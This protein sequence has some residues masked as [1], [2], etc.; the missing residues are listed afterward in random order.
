MSL[1]KPKS[2]GDIAEGLDLGDVDFD[3][4]FGTS[5]EP[6]RPE[7]KPRAPRLPPPLT[8]PPERPGT[9][10]G[11]TSKPDPP[12]TPRSGRQTLMGI[13]VGSVFD[14]EPDDTP[15]TIELDDDDFES[16]KTQIAMGGAKPPLPNLSADK[17]PEPSQGLGDLAADLD[18]IEG[19]DDFDVEK[20]NIAE[21]PLI[22]PE[23]EKGLDADSVP[24]DD[25]VDD[26][27]TEIGMS[28]E[29]MLAEHAPRGATIPGGLEAS[30]PSPDAS[31]S[32]QVDSFDE[33]AP[34][35]APE[36]PPEGFGFSN[37]DPNTHTSDSSLL[38]SPI[39]PGSSLPGE[40]DGPDGEFNAEKTE[41]LDSPFTNEPLTA[42]IHVLEGTC[43][44]QEFFVNSLRNTVG[45][46]TNNTIVVADVAMSRQHL[47][48]VSNGDGTFVLRDLQSVNGT[49]LN[50]T[51]I[52]EGDLFHG[53]RFEAGKSVFQFVLSGSNIPPVA[54]RRVVPAALQ[55]GPGPVQAA[56]PPPNAIPMQAA[57]Q[58]GSSSLMT[59]IAIAAGI[60]SMLLVLGVG[61]LWIQKKRGEQAAEQ[62]AAEGS[63]ASSLYLQGVEAVKNRKWDEAEGF[64]KK[65]RA[66]DAE[67]AGVDAQLERIG[68]ERAYAG[69]LDDARAFL[70]DGKRG[71]AVEKVSDIPRESVYY[72]EG[73]TLLRENKKLTVEE[74]YTQ[75]IAAFG[76]DDLELAEEKIV[77]IR[78]I[79]PDHGGAAELE[80]RIADAREKLAE[81][82]AVATTKSSSSKPRPKPRPKAR[83]D[84]DWGFGIEPSG[85]SSSG[86]GA[87]IVNFTKGYSLYRSKKFDDAVAFFDDKAKNSSGTWARKASDARDEIKRFKKAYNAGNSALSSGNYSSAERQLVAARRHDKSVASNGY[88]NDELAKKIATAK[89]KLGSAKLSAGDYDSAYKYAKDARNYDSGSRE[90]RDLDSALSRKAKSLYVQAANKRK[91]DP[92]QA[93]K[94]CRTIMSMT[95]ASDDSHKKAKALLNEL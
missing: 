94:L 12:P 15:G 17:R 79:V 28:L 41:L 60:V 22:F 93:A 45:R 5:G 38:P 11:P 37:F 10:T 55:T 42:K 86:G 14:D 43:A 51:R 74:L 58:G 70:E 23:D 91:T 48:I 71:L 81:D 65:A 59:K 16:E 4:I 87:T 8:K 68:K 31:A 77:E 24:T 2:S 7:A 82:K 75:A 26:D 13:G 54:N 3:S 34:P 66:M 64:F 25:L 83:P 39:A 46:G 84:D 27:K 40:D 50:G 20:T 95:P 90:L 85:K 49:A 61:V 6:K 35:A 73:Q 30:A 9:P 57:Q 18:A 56:A 88:F 1:P 69:M 32:A 92:N 19:L 78:E 76:R 47:E 52:R 67:I 36:P 33:P 80:E 44:G 63:S 72:D 29:D 21:S 62:P 89:A 53:D